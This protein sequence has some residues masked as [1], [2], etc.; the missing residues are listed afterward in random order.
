MAGA[1]TSETHPLQIAEVR[2][3]ASHGRIG[4]TFCPGKHDRAASTGAW[5]RDLATD[6]EAIAAWGARLVLTLNEPGE[7]AMLKVPHLGAAVRER[8]LD[9]RHLPIP[10]FSVPGD[11]F[12]RDWQTH[13]R[14]I[15][16]ILRSGG[17]VLVHCRGGLGRAGMIA[18]RLL[19]ELGMPPDAAIREV[20]RARRGAIETP[21]Q[22]ALVLRTTVMHD[23]D[24][25]DT[26]DAV[27]D[28]ATLEKIGGPM[29]SNPGGVYRNRQGRRF[30]VKSLETPA[31]A[32]NEIIAAG[33]YRLAGAPTLTYVRTLDA[34][35]V[36]TV[37]VELEKKHVSRLD[38]SERRQA[39]RWL[40]VHAWTANWDAAGFDGD[41]QG[42]VCG[43]V[44]TLDVGGALELRAHGDPKGK[45]F[46]TCVGEIDTLRLDPGN[47][48]AARL[49]GDMTP[50]AVAEAVAVVTRIPDDA[51]LRVVSG[52]GGSPGLAAKLIARK[53]DLA[54]RVT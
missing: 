51:V 39:Q 24:L 26:G 33:L 6:I 12:E 16:A 45:A 34:C 21:S 52:N 43:V 28:T 17:D 20:R 7:L 42:V 36:A 10:D 31:H 41:N 3:S 15:R 32:R 14:E 19:V 54:K 29:G 4:I 27:L 48:H 18:A 35:Q 49:F 25:P 23:D 9:W 53:E 8:G 5:A 50:A 1:R 38:E 44:T 40:G 11:A 37:L 22:L 47:P 30:Y 46:G 2:A 13:G